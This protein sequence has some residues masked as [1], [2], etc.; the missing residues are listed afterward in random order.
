MFHSVDLRAF[1]H[2]TEDEDRVE[3][4]LGTLCP[5]CRPVVEK[6]EGHHGNPILLMTCR[7][8]GAEAIANFWRGF[9]E[10][11]ALEGVLRDIEHRVDEDAVLHLRVDKQKAFG[12]TIELARH[13]DVIAISAKVAAHP[14]NRANAVKA[15]REYF[16]RL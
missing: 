9:K 2:A 13:D 12:G 4:A 10:A 16:Q 6:S 3:R 15:A 14:A 8:D 11:G 1:C 5:R 7:I